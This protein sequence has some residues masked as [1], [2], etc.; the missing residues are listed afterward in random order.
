MKLIPP[1]AP[2]CPRR[3][4]VAETLVLGAVLATTLYLYRGAFAGFFVQDDYGWLASSRFRSLREYGDVFF[5]FNPALT[6]RPLSQETFFFLGQKIFG[7]SP[8]GYHLV[9]VLMHLLAAVLVYIL[10]RKFCPVFPSL[11]GT[12]LFAV[13]SAHFTSVYW[14]SALPE[15]M[16]LVFML[17]SFLLF[18]R[19]D[20]RNDRVTWVLSIVAMSLAIMSKESAL[21]LPL[22]LAA[23]CLFFSRA[24]L[25]WTLPFF[26]IAGLYVVLRL[27]NIP[28]AQYPLVF[29]RESL[30]NLAAYFAWA[31]GFSQTLLIVKL[32]RDASTWYP[33]V[34]FGF[35]MASIVALALARNR[36]VA[37][38][39]VLWFIIALQPVLYFREHIFP[40]YLAPAIAALALLIGAAL[41]EPRT[42]RDWRAL[43]PAAAILCYS[44]WFAPASIRLEGRWWNERAMT[45]KRILDQMPAVDRQFPAGHIA[46]VFGFTEAEFGVLQRDAAFKAFGFSPARYVLVGL[47]PDVPRHIRTLRQD[48]GIRKYFCFYHTGDGFLNLTREF[49]RKPLDFLSPISLQQIVEEIVRRLQ[50]TSAGSRLRV[51]QAEFQRDKDTMILQVADLDADEIDLKYTLDGKPMAPVMNWRLDSDRRA[52]V[53]VS[54]S[55]SPGVYHFLAVRDSADPDPTR[56]YP[57][58]LRV[59]VR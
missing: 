6:Y 44:L 59:T 31:A 20:R 29:G 17:T 58:D 24:R 34:A 48:G 13:H 52:R 43:L 5:R 4:G 22:V 47:N 23:Y 28:V 50:Q 39:A 8:P 12:F 33:A 30:G 46:Y 21:T 7:L 36:R 3:L 35:A 57:A 11:V 37:A 45:G 9:S 40:Y 19:F 26:G 32:N 10:S 14:I 51:N 41:P 54:N 15:P 53:F 2:A 38:F 27:V 25:L 42:Y 16:A 49:R 1:R 55:T 18:I 56:W